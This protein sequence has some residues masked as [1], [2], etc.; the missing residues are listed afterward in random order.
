MT[1]KSSEARFDRRDKLLM[2][3]AYKRWADAIAL[4]SA[5]A[6]PAEELLKARQTTFGNILMT[7]NHVYV[8]DD[9]FR[10][11]LEGR[12]HTYSFRNTEAVPTLAQ[13]AAAV[14]DMDDWYVDQVRS[15]SQA[16]RDEPIA[17]KFIGGGAGRLSREDIV[18]HVVN[19]TTY[20]RGFVGDMLK[21]FPY[22]WPANDLT[23]FVRDVWSAGGGA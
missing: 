4:E 15:W 1:D 2:L 6:I 22:H 17:F 10:H 11:H 7:L 19:H 16:E 12:P 21:Q 3:V 23:V 8:V 14:R 13:L 20:H 5:R 9:I 18:L